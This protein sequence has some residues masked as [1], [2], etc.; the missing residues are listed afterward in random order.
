MFRPVW[1]FYPAWKVYVLFLFYLIWIP[2]LH[3]DCVRSLVSCVLLRKIMR[4]DMSKLARRENACDEP[5]SL[6]RH[7]CPAYVCFFKCFTTQDD[8]CKHRTNKLHGSRI[9]IIWIDIVNTQFINSGPLPCVLMPLSPLRLD[10]FFR[11][12]CGFLAQNNKRRLV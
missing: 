12:H 4:V 2:C 10:L 1:P 8:F 3:A 9:C 7:I 6:W 11:R 5:L